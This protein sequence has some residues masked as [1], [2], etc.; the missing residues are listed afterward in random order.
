M[1]KDTNGEEVKLV[2]ILNGETEIYMYVYKTDMVE[3]LMEVVLGYV[4]EIEHNGELLSEIS[5]DNYYDIMK[6]RKARLVED[7][8]L[9]LRNIANE[10]L[11][12]DMICHGC[13]QDISQ[14]RLI[15]NT[16]T[17]LRCKYEDNYIAE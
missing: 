11:I 9:Y 1:L 12:V 17:C 5:G 10:G 14:G 3:D 8:S 16:V 13:C 2:D 15:N 4:K 6:L 7:F